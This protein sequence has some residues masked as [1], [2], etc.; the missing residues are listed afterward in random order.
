MTVFKS[1]ENNLAYKIIFVLLLIAIIFKDLL[2][3]LISNK[4][5]TK[6]NNKINNKIKEGMD[7]FISQ[8]SQ[9]YMA[10]NLGNIL[11]IQMNLTVIL[12]SKLNQ[13]NHYLQKI[14]FYLNVV[15]IIINIQQIELSMY[16]SRTTI[17][18]AKK[19]C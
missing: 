15:F 10:N 18:F 2:Y 6:I 19:W 3:S 5:N 8:E 16:Y 12:M 17:L 9:D 1:L 7:L 14:N 4:T 13:N 11:N